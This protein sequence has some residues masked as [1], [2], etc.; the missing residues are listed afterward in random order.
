MKVLSETVLPAIRY[1][2]SRNR[3]VDALHA[4]IIHTKD[5]TD[6]L[7][8][9]GDEIKKCKDKIGKEEGYLPHIIYSPHVE[10][11][12][13]NVSILHELDKETV[14][15]LIKFYGGLSDIEKQIDGF[16]KPSYKAISKEGQIEA[17]K[18]LIATIKKTAFS[19]RIPG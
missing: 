1:F 7:R 17:F 14:P 19:I 9:S 10:I 11:F 16:P 5:L 4:E 12:N 6:F 2:W 13:A 18:F 3:L 8:H 15:H